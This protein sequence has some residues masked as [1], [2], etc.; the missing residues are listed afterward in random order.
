MIS[1]Q[2]AAVSPT[3]KCLYLM[4]EVSILLDFVSLINPQNIM[5]LDKSSSSV[6]CLVVFG[7]YQFKL[8]NTQILYGAGQFKLIFMHIFMSPNVQTLCFVQQEADRCVVNISEKGSG[9]K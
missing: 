2:N 6:F 8:E 9:I 4:V 7:F 3:Y 5:H 1:V